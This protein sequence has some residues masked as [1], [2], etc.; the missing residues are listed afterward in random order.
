MSRRCAAMER[1]V[2]NIVATVI[3]RGY[4]LAIDEEVPNE[5]DDGHNGTRR[6]P[7]IRINA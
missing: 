4:R 5:S 6:P 2:E 7:K 3:K 1:K